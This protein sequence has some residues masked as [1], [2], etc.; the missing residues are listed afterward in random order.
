MVGRQK[1]PFATFFPAFLE[2]DDLTVSF[3]VA[4]EASRTVWLLLIYFGEKNPK[5]LVS[6]LEGRVETSLTSTCRSC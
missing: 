1:M 3:C 6:Y 2:S 5:P 4:S